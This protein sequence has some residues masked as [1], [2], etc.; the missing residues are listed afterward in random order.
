[1][2]TRKAP[3][4][5]KQTAPTPAERLKARRVA[6]REWTPKKNNIRA[7]QRQI[8]AALAALARG[9]A[10]AAEA[11]LV[12]ARTSLESALE[13]YPGGGPNVLT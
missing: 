2:A 5:K 10:S 11:A 1:M 12:S 9:R 6:R 8:T 3:A 7:A 13:G 4:R